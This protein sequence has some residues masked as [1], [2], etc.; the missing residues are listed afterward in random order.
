M[1]VH[2]DAQTLRV[3]EAVTQQLESE[4]QAAAMSTVVTA[5][6]NTRI[7]VEGMR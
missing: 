5:E 2:S 1:A 6:L 3:A 7:L 4:I